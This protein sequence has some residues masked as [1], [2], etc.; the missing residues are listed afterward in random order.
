MSQ[1]VTVAIAAPLEREH[2]ELIARTDPAVDVLYEPDLL[3]PERFPADHGGDPAFR[4][5][6]SDE[7]RFWTMLERADVL[8]G[9]PGQSAQGLAEVVRRNRRLRWIHAMAAGAG[10]VV[11]AAGLQPAEL[12]RVAITTSSGVHAIPLAEFALLGAL[13]GLKGLPELALDQRN[14]VWPTMRRPA[15]MLEGSRMVVAGLGEIGREIAR[16]ATA[17]GMT[18]SGT[19]RRVE[20]IPGIDKVATNDDLVDLA[21]TADVLVNALPGTPQTEGLIGRDVF[22]ALRTGAVFV[23]V[24]RGSVVDEDALLVALDDGS[25]AFACLDVFANEPLPADSLLWNHPRVMVSPHSAA[26]SVSENRLIAEQFARY[27][28]LFLDGNPLPHR[29]DPVFYY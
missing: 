27:L 24:G 4:R 16:R 5:S 11:R 28:K 20:P 25:L 23:N 1:P 3:P 6:A 2:V 12:D 21:G 18:V 19:K 10:A 26:L 15:R 8:Y 17:L 14:R 7:H 22:A 13:A 29:V 9:F